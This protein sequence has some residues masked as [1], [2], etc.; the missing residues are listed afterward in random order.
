MALLGEMTLQP[1]PPGVDSKILLDKNLHKIVGDG[2]TQTIAFAAQTSWL[3][4]QSI[5]DNIIFGSPFDQERYNQVVDACALR[6]D[7]DILEDGDLTEIGAKYLFFYM[8][9]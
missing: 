2:L 7:F 3:Q 4:H 9:L 8:W 6:P 5:R 1:S